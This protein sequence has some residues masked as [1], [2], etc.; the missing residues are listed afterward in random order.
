[1][2]DH[3]SLATSGSDQ[4]STPPS[5]PMPD[6]TQFR[7]ML[8]ERAIAHDFACLMLEF[9]HGMKE[10]ERQYPFKIKEEDGDWLIQGAVKLSESPWR[11]RVRKADCMV[12]EIGHIGPPL[13][14]L[15]L[16]GDIDQAALH[17][18]PPE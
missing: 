14:T 1:M 17:A 12:K 4:M 15:D 13:E 10:F 9:R 3:A 18:K 11:M 6:L 8:S 16:N 5:Y 2:V 7:P